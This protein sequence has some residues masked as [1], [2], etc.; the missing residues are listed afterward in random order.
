MS[1]S[2]TVS[3]PANVALAVESIE[4][5]DVTEAAPSTLKPAAE[6]SAPARLVFTTPSPSG[7]ESVGTLVFDEHEGRTTLTLT[8]TCA[9][10]ADRD[11]LLARRVDVGTTHTLDNLDAYLAGVRAGLRSV[12]IHNG[13][14]TR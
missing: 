4:P 3:V 11:E 8:I 7:A 5:P 1:P 10:R 12:A 6:I 14:S 2:S 9:S 13:E